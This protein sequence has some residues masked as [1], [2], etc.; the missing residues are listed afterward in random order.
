MP[1]DPTRRAAF[2]TGLRDLA[3]F[4]ETNPGV[5]VPRQSTAITYFPEQ[6]TDA[7]MCAEVDR[8][9]GLCGSRIDPAPLPY[10]HYM[11]TLPFGPLRY[12][13]AAILADARARYGALSSYHGCVTPDS[14]PAH[15][16]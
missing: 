16:A 6:A 5:P 7:E 12:E 14:D 13:I 4:I 10:G 2:I 9:A 8:I 15:V 1:T 11:I 3:D